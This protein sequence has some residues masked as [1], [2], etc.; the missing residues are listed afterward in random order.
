MFS[1]RSGTKRPTRMEPCQFLHASIRI[2]LPA[3]STVPPRPGGQ[4]WESQEFPGLLHVLQCSR[5]RQVPILPRY[6]CW[7]EPTDHGSQLPR[8][9]VSASQTALENQGRRCTFDGVYLLSITAV[10]AHPHAPPC[11][12]LRFPCPPAKPSA[13]Y[14]PRSSR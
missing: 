11:A 2:Y 12:P 14:D 10:L 3:S 1:V 9:S 13:C 8:F 7:K 6:C 4:S 5:T